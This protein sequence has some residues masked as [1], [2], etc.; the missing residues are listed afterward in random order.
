MGSAS[1]QISPT[2]AETH[3]MPEEASS[4]MVTVDYQTFKELFTAQQTPYLRKLGIACSILFVA[5]TAFSIMMLLNQPSAETMGI[6][7]LFAILAAFGIKMATRPFVLMETREP[8]VRAWF[9]DHGAAFAECTPAKDLTATYSI[10]LTPLGFT[11]ETSKGRNAIPWFALSGTFVSG[12]RADY[13]TAADGKNSSI[14]YNLTG[15][16]WMLRDEHVP[17]ILVVPKDMTTPQLKQAV[18]QAIEGSKR[19][20]CST[21]PS[22]GDC[23]DLRNW[24][25]Q[26]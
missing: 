23:V 11:E 1:T 7:L 4:Y 3:P 8:L 10:S 25:L 20:Y 19:K 9:E 18:Q 16:N 22:N 21:S 5:F 13:F 15:I 17:T 2:S 14:A 24:A 6:T 26:S 12:K